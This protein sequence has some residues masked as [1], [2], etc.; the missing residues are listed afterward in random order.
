MPVL[1]SIISNHDLVAGF[2]HRLLLQLSLMRLQAAACNIFD[3][4]L[5]HRKAHRQ[6]YG[7][8]GTMMIIKDGGASSD[9]AQQ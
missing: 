4:P 7:L 3:A 9:E 6:A 8:L 1:Q 2:S 5:P